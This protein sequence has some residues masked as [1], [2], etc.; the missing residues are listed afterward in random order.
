MFCIKDM[1]TACSPMGGLNPT[2]EK[3]LRKFGNFKKIARKLGI[4]GTFP[5]SH[6]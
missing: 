2:Q 1:P 3:D 5:P 6:H 4:E